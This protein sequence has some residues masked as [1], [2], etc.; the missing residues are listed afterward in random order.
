MPD[1]RA[2]LYPAFK[3]V[4]QSSISLASPPYR[5]FLNNIDPENMIH[6]YKIAVGSKAKWK[7]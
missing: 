6:W 2:E 7:I 4:R 5:E 3:C 1:A